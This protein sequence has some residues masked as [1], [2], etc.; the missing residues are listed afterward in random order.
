[1]STT[2]NLHLPINDN[3]IKSNFNFYPTEKSFTTATITFGDTTI[4]YYFLDNAELLNFTK[5]LA[6]LVE[7]AIGHLS[8]GNKP[9]NSGESPL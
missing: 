1:M 8:N 7:Q 9:E 2:I 5:C 6:D 3:T 4:T